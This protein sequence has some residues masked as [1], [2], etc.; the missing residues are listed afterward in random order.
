LTKNPKVK[1]KRVYAELETPFNEDIGSFS[2]GLAK[3]KE[4]LA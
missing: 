1:E 4:S 2:K 3:F